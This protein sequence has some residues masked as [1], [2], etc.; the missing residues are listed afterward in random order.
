MKK[1]TENVYVESERSVCNTS[2]VVTGEGVVVIDTPMLPADAKAVAA[3]ISEYGP[4]RY[5]INTEPHSDH[6]FGNCYFGGLCVG[7]EGT[8]Q[9]ILDST[10]EG[11][12]EMLKGIH[13]EALPLPPDFRLRP[14]DITFTERLS[15]HLGNHTFNLV[16]M[17]GHTPYQVAVHVPEERLVFT[18]DNISLG[19]AFFRQAV[20]DAWLQTLDKMEELDVDI[21]VPGH[22]KPENKSCFKEMSRI[23]QRWLDVVGA[24]IDKG[25][26][27]EEARDSIR[28]T[29][30][31]P[32]AADNPHTSGAVRLNVEK[33]YEYLK[34]R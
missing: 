22:G 11:M 14:S 32:G 20:P 10:V 7:H 21:V 4:V 31:Y 23:V 8:R 3:E 28:I 25:M 13:P 9:T 12:T 6:I 15:L 24:A 30:I 17:P 34:R 26:S 19:M 33:L 18:S 29:D 5:L 2:F 16:H 27:I 1:I